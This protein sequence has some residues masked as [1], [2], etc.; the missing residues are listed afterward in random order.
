MTTDRSSAIALIIIIACALLPWLLHGTTW[1]DIFVAR[2]D[3]CNQLSCDFTRHYLP[4]AT[5]IIT[6]SDEFARGWFYPPLLGITLIPFTGLADPDLWWTALNLICA[7][8]L[9]GLCAQQ[10]K[11][12]SRMVG[13][14]AGIALV[15]SSLPVA[16]SIKWGQIS[17]LIATLACYGLL[18]SKRTAGMV[19]GTL[20][21]LKAYP[22]CYGILP[23]ISRCRKT[24][25]WMGVSLAVL[26]LLIPFALLGMDSMWAYYVRVFDSG[27]QIQMIAAGGGGQALM[28]TMTR[29]FV[30]GSH[31]MLTEKP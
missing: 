19:L 26:G 22:I 23:L 25:A 28:P 2:L 27:R 11:T 5:N 31:I 10:L 7:I 15:A 14:L 13:W 6:G 1:P 29:W 16:H 24:L 20:A 12:R 3:H 17:L 8:G 21:A 9:A 4:Q 18:A 30:D